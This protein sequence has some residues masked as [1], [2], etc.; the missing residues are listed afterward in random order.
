MRKIKEVLRLYFESHMSIRR[1]AASCSLSRSAVSDMIAR[2][3]AARVSWP[4]PGELGDSELEALLYP[5][6]LAHL[7]H[8]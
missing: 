8:P 2:A 4:L 6:P 5:Q 3:V 7:Q 1:I